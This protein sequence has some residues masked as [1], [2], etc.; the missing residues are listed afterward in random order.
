M[1]LASL[2]RRIAALESE[3]INHCLFCDCLSERVE[4]LSDEELRELIAYLDGNC[5][6]V[7]PELEN[8]FQIC[9][10]R[11]LHAHIAI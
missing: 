3:S 5:A 9:L 7:G 10:N 8:C 6:T 11:A 4:A 2:A 1:R